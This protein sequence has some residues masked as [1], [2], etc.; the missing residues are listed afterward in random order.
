MSL[1]NMWSIFN[2]PIFR[3]VYKLKSPRQL[4]ITKLKCVQAHV[5]KFSVCNLMRLRM[6]SYFRSYTPETAG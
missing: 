3:L 1:S 6:R 4:P 2:I 5:S